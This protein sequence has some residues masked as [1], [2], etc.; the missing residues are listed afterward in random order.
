MP[1]HRTALPAELKDLIVLIR[2]GMLFDVQRWIRDG[3]PVRLPP[4]VR[5][6]ISP[7]L[8]AIRTGNHSMVQ[9][10]LDE[11]ASNVDLGELMAEAV[12][13]KRLDLCQ[14]IHRYG[15]NPQEVCYESVASSHNPAMLRWFEDHGIDLEY[16]LALATALRWRLRAALGTYMRQRNRNPR[17]KQ[18]IDMALRYH[19]GVGDLK[20]VSLLTWAGADPRISVPLFSGEY[21]EEPE[22]NALEEAVSQGHADIV[23]KFKIDSR[24]DDLDNLLRRSG[25][26]ANLEIVTMLLDAGANPGAG[27]GE[28][29]VRRYVQTLG[30][31]LAGDFRYRRDYQNLTTILTLFAGKGA[32]WAPRD[33]HDLRNFRKGFIK[34]DSSAAIDVL[35]RL[36]RAGF[37]TQPVFKEL[38]STPAM[39]KL[40][41]PERYGILELREFAGFAPLRISKKRRRKY[42]KQ[43]T[44][45]P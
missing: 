36:V 30:W 16:D 14:L 4:S 41:R 23:R 12:A 18:Q 34:A 21:S 19:A 43:G 44:S 25:S 31:T 32:T 2:A 40:L 22:G 45:T 17:L 37:L 8:A 7:A 10:I 1:Q 24:R 3:K 28:S 29:A 20:W 39:R 42:R 5:F 38:A 9:V 13:M 11:V 26:G 27:G 33:R 35:A 15:G 6:A